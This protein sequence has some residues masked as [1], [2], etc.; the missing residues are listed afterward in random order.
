VQPAFT[1]VSKG[2]LKASHREKDAPHPLRPFYTHTNPQPLDAG[3]IYQFDI[4]AALR[5]MCSEGHRIRLEI[6]MAIRAHR[7]GVHAS[8]HPTLIGSDNPSRCRAC[9]LHHAAGGAERLTRLILGVV[10]AKAGTHNHPD[11]R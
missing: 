3:E 7:R 4:G 10:P 8:Y 1:N 11:S 6:A 2:W 9:V 5:P